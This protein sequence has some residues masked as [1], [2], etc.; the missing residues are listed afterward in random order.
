MVTLDVLEEGVPATLWSAELEALS[1]VPA[2]LVT[3]ARVHYFQA[4][5]LERAKP[6]LRDVIALATDLVAPHEPYRLIQR[7]DWHGNKCVFELEPQG[8]F[9][10]PKRR[11]A[12][13][14]VYGILADLMTGCLARDLRVRFHRV[15]DFMVQ[16]SL[17]HEPGPVEWRPT[18]LVLGAIFMLAV[19]DLN[20]E[21][22][23]VHLGVPV[24]V[25]VE[26]AFDFDF[27]GHES[28]AVIVRRLR[29][30]TRA[31]EI[32]FLG[33]SH[34]G[35]GHFARPEFVEAFVE[36][37]VFAREALCRALPD[38]TVLDGL[39]LRR[40]ILPTRVYLNFIRRNALFGWEAEKAIA[41]WQSLRATSA[42]PAVVTAEARA[43]LT[44]NVPFFHRQGANLLDGADGSRLLEVSCPVS[45]EAE[46]WVDRWPD[47]R[48]HELAK[49]L[50]E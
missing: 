36:G 20:F 24:P 16:E 43:L 34:P 6:H 15:G 38:F 29:E 1:L 4:Q 35:E 40:V 3:A 46:K 7:G 18:G 41:H 27:Y 44:G 48:L 11:G 12:E 8:L 28:Q 32:S 50:A 25:D 9:L 22:F 5:L 17:G 19:T 14:L 23:R 39:F 33:P 42:I 47:Q 2:K 26:C 45:T 13:E 10:K 30:Q 21:N 31:I 49:A 37:A